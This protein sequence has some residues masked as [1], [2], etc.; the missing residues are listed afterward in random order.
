MPFQ[1]AFF[2]HTLQSQGVALGYVPIA[3][4]GRAHCVYSLRT[5]CIVLPTVFCLEELNLLTLNF[6]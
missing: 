3:L 5:L 2:K 4:S 1:G 6:A